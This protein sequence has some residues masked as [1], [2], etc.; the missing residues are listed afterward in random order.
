MAGYRT[1]PEKRSQAGSSTFVTRTHGANSTN[2]YPSR[3]ARVSPASDRSDKRGVFHSLSLEISFALCVLALCFTPGARAVQY[4]FAPLCAAVAYYLLRKDRLRYIAFSLNLWFY[5]PLVRRLADFHAGFLE[6]NPVLLAPFLV[7]GLAIFGS[8]AH[9]GRL[10]QRNALP[11]A[12]CLLGALYGVVVGLLQLPPQAV[13]TDS[14]RWIVGILFAYVCFV[15]E[16]DTLAVTRTVQRVFTSGLLI[17]SVYGIW[18]NFSPVPW[19]IYWMA[20][21]DASSFGSVHDESI[22][23]FSTMN[24]PGPFA[25]TA[26]A[27]V[28]LLASARTKLARLAQILGVVVVLESFVRSAWLGLIA[29]LLYLFLQASRRVRMQLVGAVCIIVVLLSILLAKPELGGKL[30]ERLSTLTQLKQDE[31]VGE[32]SAG[33]R[34][35]FAHVIQRPFGGGFGFL[36][37][38]F[39]ASH[40]S[41][42]TQ[43]GAHDNGFYEF[44][45]TLG[46]PG[47]L[48]YFLGLVGLMGPVFTKS[49]SKDGIRGSLYAAAICFLVQLPTGNSLFGVDGAVCWLCAALAL[50]QDSLPLRK[51]LKAMR[52]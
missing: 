5:T 52:V 21:V 13:F 15:E 19:D 8:K 27:G 38:R 44:L 39:E 35:A 26:A 33:A 48:L 2:T 36:D 49:R 24:S 3:F 11:F 28:L 16:D 18:Q 7:A 29:G 6:P 51:P 9:A 14:L 30:G 1:E 45:A 42:G 43:F 10:F 23:V 34:R 22:R 37:T 12:L 4:L 47:S 41:A 25:A 50:R 46:I 17:M 32:R 31:S 40:D 20:N